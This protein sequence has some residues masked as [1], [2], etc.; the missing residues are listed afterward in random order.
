MPKRNNRSQLI[1]I[2]IEHLMI[3]R[4][5][6]RATKLNLP[7]HR[8]LKACAQIGL[9]QGELTW[10]RLAVMS[11]QGVDESYLPETS[12]VYF[13]QEESERGLIKI[14][15]TQDLEGRLS[16]LPVEC[17]YP[18]RLLR[19]VPG[20]RSLET[21]LL[22]RFTPHR[23]ATPWAGKDWFHPHPDVLQYLLGMSEP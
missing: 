14:G 23:F 22:T 5:K 17:Q 1:S 16:S 4:V 7:W 10:E 19:S 2:R 8:V 13:V 21:E 6:E 11:T 20:G 3:E 15:W 12:C 18:V 9:D